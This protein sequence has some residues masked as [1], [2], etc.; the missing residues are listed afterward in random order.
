MTHS[1]CSCYHYLLN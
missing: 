1:S